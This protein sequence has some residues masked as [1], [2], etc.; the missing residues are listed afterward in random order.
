MDARQRDTIEA[1][2][3]AEIEAKFV[4]AKESKDGAGPEIRAKLEKTRREYREKWRLP[5]G[6][7]PAT[8]TASGKP[9]AVGG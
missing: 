8:V 6:V 3:L 1:G 5:A 4:A 2:K 9:E 7:Q